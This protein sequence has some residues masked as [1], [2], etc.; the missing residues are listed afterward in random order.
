MA[1]QTQ[2]ASR[3]VTLAVAE[4]VAGLRYV[5]LPA[6]TREVIRWAILDT[7]GCGVNGLPTEW[8]QL[9]LRWAE[10]GQGGKG[11][12][13]VWG[14]A[15][16]SLR[17]ADAA[18]V[19]GTAI[20]SFELDDYHRVKL[21]PGAVVI[22]AAFAV[23]EKLGSSG[24]EILTAVAAGYEVTI[25]SS[26]ALDPSAGRLRGWHLT[27]ICG[28]LGAAAACAK[29]MG[30]TAEQTAWA[31]GLGGT[32]GA[33]LWAFTADGAMSKRLHPGRAAHAAV[34]AAE[35]AAAGFTGPTQIY[36]AADGGFLKA[37]SDAANASLLVEGLGTHYW[38]DDLCT[39]PYSCCGSLHAYIDAARELRRQT[40]LPAGSRTKVKVGM[41]KVVDVQ[42]G[43]DYSPPTTVLNAQMSARYCIAVSLLEGAALPPQFQPEKLID[44]EIVALA[45]SIELVPDPALDNLYPKHF[46]GW[47]AVEHEGDWKRIDVLD[48][49]GSPAQPLGPGGIKEKFHGL[50]EG[51]LSREQALAV[52]QAVANFESVSLRDLLAKLA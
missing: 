25:R 20:H 31:I 13:T 11:Q 19:N 1:V 49:S 15:Q 5:D 7:V 14:Q 38:S 41:S 2:V 45:Q 3:G 35:L 47:V 43:F 12:A 4:W 39:K 29:L 28:P 33:G 37:H 32:Q 48:P 23:A 16:P 52:E 42:C 50:V 40:G 18:L 36:E 26:L 34:L 22:P 17:A 21:H 30:L 24:K 6:T 8:A 44:P 27:G 10:E 9:V 51:I 46:A